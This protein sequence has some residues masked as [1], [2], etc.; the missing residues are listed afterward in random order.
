[1]QNYLLIS[2][3]ILWVAIILL[4]TLF[5]SLA[6]FVATFLNNFRLSL[7][8]TKLQRV[9]LQAGEQAPDL[10]LVDQNK[11]PITLND[12]GNKSTLLLFTS[13]R[14]GVCKELYNHLWKTIPSLSSLQF[15]V[16]QN[17][18]NSEIP[19]IPNEIVFTQSEDAFRKYFIE[20]VPELYLINEKGQIV[21]KKSVVQYE[22]IENTIKSYNLLKIS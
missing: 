10:H 4:T 21:L 6:K 2:N 17:T 9:T 19:N 12:F 18:I 16:I 7:D 22:D 20:K 11:N 5:F 14:C 3:I 8:N 15:I 13:E 1:M